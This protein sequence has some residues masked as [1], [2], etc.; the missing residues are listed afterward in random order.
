MQPLLS[1]SSYFHSRVLSF[2]PS[3]VLLPFL[4]PFPLLA[5]SPPAFNPLRPH[6]VRWVQTDRFAS[7]RKKNRIPIYIP[8]TKPYSHV[9]MIPRM[10]SRKDFVSRKN[11]N[12]LHFKFSAKYVKHFYEHRVYQQ[13]FHHAFVAFEKRLR[14]V[15]SLHYV[16]R[17]FALKVKKKKE[18][19]T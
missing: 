16:Q 6:G 3:F 8:S 15:Y 18:K 19:K 17:L 14:Y 9:A 2:Q 13:S 12:T 5:A 1:I 10:I 11:S 4:F 7:F